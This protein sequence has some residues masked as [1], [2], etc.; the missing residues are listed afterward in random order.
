MDKN[1]FEKLIESKN[2]SNSTTIIPNASVENG[3]SA[4]IQL[5]RNTSNNVKMLVSAFESRIPETL[6]YKEA[7]EEALNARG[8]I[9][10]VIFRRQ[11]NENSSVYKMLLNYK[12]TDKGDKIGLRII[13]DEALQLLNNEIDNSGNEFHF[14]VSDDKGYRFEKDVEKHTAWVC[15]NDLEKAGRLSNIFDNIYGLSKDIEVI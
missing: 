8:I 6:G 2:L 7:L 15:F 14:A 12:K 3:A 1:R 13:T 11:P 10:E 9:I 4:M 5:F